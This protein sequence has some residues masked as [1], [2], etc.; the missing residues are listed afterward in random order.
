[1]V[2][3]LPLLLFLVCV[4]VV[5]GIF[6]SVLIIG[7]WKPEVVWHVKEWLVALKWGKKRSQRL[8]LAVAIFCVQHGASRVVLGNVDN[9]RVIDF[10]VLCPHGSALVADLPLS[11]GSA[12]LFPFLDS[13]SIVLRGV[14]N[15]W[16]AGKGKGGQF[17]THKRRER[18][19]ESVCVCVCVGE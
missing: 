8:F 1:M 14:R 15:A 4:I 10:L 9:L 12:T 5:L 3:A 13:T 16:G 6:S 17:Q 7:V 2:L 19:R 18:E 11:H